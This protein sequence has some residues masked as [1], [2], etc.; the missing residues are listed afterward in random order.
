MKLLFAH[1]QTRPLGRASELV[2]EARGLIGTF[3]VARTQAG[4]EAI[5]LVASGSI[6]SFSV[7]FVP[8][9]DSWTRGSE[10]VDRLEV[11]LLETSLV[12]LPAFDG[13]RIE[14]MRS[15]LQP[16]DPELDPELLARALDLSHLRKRY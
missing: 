3:K 12:T 16:Y 4:D 1:D 9:T 13:A 10:H 7:G 8:I 11:K 14:S 15:A 2:E 5:E 6:D